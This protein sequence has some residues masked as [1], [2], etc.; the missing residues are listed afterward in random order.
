MK[1]FRDFLDVIGLVAGAAV[2][3]VFLAL[4]AFH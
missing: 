3:V 1:R 4:M 2:F